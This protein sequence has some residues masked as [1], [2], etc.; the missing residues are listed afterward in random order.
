MIDSSEHHEQVRAINNMQI[1][2]MEM[3]E[4]LVARRAEFWGNCGQLVARLT[5]AI[6]QEMERKAAKR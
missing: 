6:E 2:I 5:S 1:R 4:Q 3:K